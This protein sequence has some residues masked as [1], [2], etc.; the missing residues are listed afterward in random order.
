MNCLVFDINTEVIF[1]KL[2]PRFWLVTPETGDP[3]TVFIEYLRTI[4]SGLSYYAGEM[5]VNCETLEEFLYNSGQHLALEDKLN[6][7]FDPTLERIYITENNVSINNYVWYLQGETDPINKVWYLQG[8]LNPALEIWYLQGEIIS[9][10]NFSVNVPA[11]LSSF[12]DQIV[13]MLNNYVVNAYKFNII[14]F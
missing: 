6:R 13:S 3:K 5:L 1:L 10:F 2:V 9:L 4:A 12:E 14:Y 7:N 8:E 11:A